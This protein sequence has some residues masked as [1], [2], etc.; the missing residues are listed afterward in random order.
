MTLKQLQYFL[1]LSKTCHFTS[2]A[3]QLFISQSSLSYAISVLEKELNVNL[4]ERHGGTITLSKYGKAYAEQ[5]EPILEQLEAANRRIELMRDPDKSEVRFGV[6]PSLY[7]EFTYAA[8]R[9]FGDYLPEQT[10]ELNIVGHKETE[11]KELLRAEQLDLCLCVAPDSEFDSRRLF[12]QELML[13]VPLGHRLAERESV[14]LAEIADE[15]FILPTRD[16][17]FRQQVD[18]IFRRQGLVYDLVSEQ[19]SITSTLAHVSNGQGVSILPQSASIGMYRAKA[20]RILDNE[21]RRTVYLAWLSSR[22]LPHAVAAVRTFLV[23]NAAQIYTES[24]S[25]HRQAEGS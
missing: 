7:K 5:I 10:I 20:V 23:K 11:L 1:A 6:F 17:M 16:H 12:T 9:A 4:F 18:A 21:F 13:Y 25:L 3:E 15:K 14:E 8:I 22:K 19:G 2:T 24:L